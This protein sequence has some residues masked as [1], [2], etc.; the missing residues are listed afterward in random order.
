MAVG[1]EIDEGRLQ[2][3]FDPADDALVNI[4]FFLFP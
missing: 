2:T 1:T 4:G 3:G